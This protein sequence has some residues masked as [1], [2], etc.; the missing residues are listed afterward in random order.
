MENNNNTKTS[1]YLSFRLGDEHF[2]V[3]A[4]KV[5]SILEMIRITAVPKSPG[6][7]RGVIN[8]RGIVLPIVD[9]RIRLGMSPTEITANTCIIVLEVNIDGQPARIGA[10]VD[11]VLSVVEL[12]Y[13]QILPPPCIGSKYQS[14]HIT[15]ITN[16]DE[17][18]LMILDVDAVLSTIK[19]AIP[20][21][22]QVA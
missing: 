8:L 3:H 6:F 17:R 22:Q 9:T 1:S 5:L 18:F 20:A 12:D 13:S 2:A 7:M 4:G 11:A 14:D 19:Q 16:V 10:L 15:G 21:Q